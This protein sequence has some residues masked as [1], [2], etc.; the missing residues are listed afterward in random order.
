MADEKKPLDE[1][2]FFEDGP[3]PGSEEK[4]ARQEAAPAEESADGARVISYLDQLSDTEEEKAGYERAKAP[5]MKPGDRRFFAICGG[6]DILLLV[7]IGVCLIVTGA[8]EFSAQTTEPAT[9]SQTQAAAPAPDGQTDVLSY[10]IAQDQ[11]LTPRIKGVDF[12]AGIQDRFRTLYSANQDTAG[13]LRIN[14]T[15]IDYAVMH[16]DSNDKYHR[17]SFFGKYNRRG[18][19]YMDFRCTVA[20]RSGLKNVTILYGHHLSRDACVFAPVENYMDVE[21]YKTQPVI[22]MDTIYEDM[23]WKVFACFTSTVDPKDDNG[24]VFYYWNP[25]IGSNELQAF[26][27]EMLTRSYIVNPTVDVQPTDKILLIST[28]T[29]VIN[30]VGARCVLAARLV[31]EGESE[32]VD[33]SGAYQNTNRRMPQAWYDQRGLDNPFRDVPVTFG[34]TYDSAAE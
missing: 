22:E 10:E 13:W 21:F 31:R 20:P 25:E 18:S 4:A 32:A 2:S 24:N 12:P 8:A 30:N 11:P 5:R 15:C 6:L 23:K 34:I 9:Q 28:C 19:C 3:A 16:A 17:A 14:G 7:V 29:Y 33:V 27:Q 1:L 26:A